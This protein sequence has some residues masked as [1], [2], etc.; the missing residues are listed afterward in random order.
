MAEDELN[1]RLTKLREEWK[2]FDA[3]ALIRSELGLSVAQA[4]QYL[5]D[6]PAWHEALAR[7]DDT[8]D[9]LEQKLDESGR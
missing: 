3:I 6:H 7:W 8:L 5:H 2:P 1:G 4:K 9:E